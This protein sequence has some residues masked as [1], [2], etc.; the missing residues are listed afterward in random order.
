MRRGPILLIDNARIHT[1]KVVYEAMSDLKFEKLEHPPYSPDLAPSD[2]LLFTNLKQWQRGCKFE[3]LEELEAEVG[4]WFASQPAA[5]YE[6]GFEA[7][8]ERLKRVRDSGGDY[9]D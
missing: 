6:G 2:Y 3:D 1:A 5:F 9:L 7:L 4:A 8:K